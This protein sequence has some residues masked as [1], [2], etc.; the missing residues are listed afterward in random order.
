MTSPLL[1]SFNKG[2]DLK[3]KYYLSGPMNGYE[4]NNFPAF[5]GACDALRGIGIKLLSPHE[6]QSESEYLTWAQ[7]LNLDIRILMD[8]DGLILLK[9]WPKSKGARLELDIA[10]DLE[11]PIWYYHNYDLREM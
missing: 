6:K 11:Y 9:G 7:Y 1:K 10:M 8:C 5:Q 2:F 4:D 3:L